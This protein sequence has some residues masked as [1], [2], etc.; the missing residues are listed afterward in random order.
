VV[1]SLSLGSMQEYTLFGKGFFDL[2]DFVTAKIMLPLSGLLV[3]IF[4]GWYLKRSVSYAELTNGGKQKVG[5]LGLYMFLLRYVAP[6]AI[7]L[8][9]INELGLI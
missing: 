1:S 5:F 7:A 4:V 9:F 2:L 8:I 3:C 6:I